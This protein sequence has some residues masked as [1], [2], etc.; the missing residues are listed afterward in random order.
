MCLLEK[1]CWY[2]KSGKHTTHARSNHD[3]HDQI[4]TLMFIVTENPFVLIVSSDTE[5]MHMRPCFACTA[6]SPMDA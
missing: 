3:V 1:V 2:A 5:P 6:Y 4:T